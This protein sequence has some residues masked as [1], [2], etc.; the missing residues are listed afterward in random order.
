MNNIKA[1]YDATLT[2]AKALAA[3]AAGRDFTDDELAVAAELQR[4][5]LDLEPRVR[6]AESDA[7]VKAAIDELGLGIGV[8]PN[9]VPSVNGGQ[10]KADDPAAVKDTTKAATTKA[11][12]VSP[13]VKATGGTCGW[14]E[15][16]TKKLS[17]PDGLKS[18]LSGGAIPVSV[19]LNPEPVRIGEP[20]L[21]M[22]QLIPSV[23]DT[24][25]RW[26]YLRQVTRTNNAA[27]V[28]P[29]AKKPTSVYALARVD[30]R[31]RVIATLS[32]P[33][34]KQD[35]DDAP[36]LMDFLDTEMRLGLDL[37]LENEILTGSGSGEHF[38][39]ISNVS[40]SQSQAYSND[41]FETTRKAITKLEIINLA[42]T[43]WVFH[44]S[45]WELSLIH[46]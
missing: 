30:D 43:G 26:S 7:A 13:R 44:P 29:G 31:A 1:Q 42:P 20:V 21:S 33:I 27:V 28:A 22:L 41:L 18:L 17:T 34:S 15:A 45:D 35:L 12:R 36:T 38:M 32:E 39:G 16:V 23:R 37:A 40:G 3:K 11:T 14:G 46:I 2:A 19:P 24:V 4:R 25:G 5:A 10:V 9:L 6:Q 8:D